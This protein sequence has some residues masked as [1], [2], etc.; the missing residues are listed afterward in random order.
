MYAKLRA[1]AVARHLE[2]TGPRPHNYDSS[3]GQKEVRQGGPLIRALARWDAAMLC[4]TVL[5]TSFIL[6]VSAYSP[7]DYLFW[8]IIELAFIAQALLHWPYLLFIVPFMTGILTGTSHTACEPT[9]V[10]T[11]SATPL[12]ALARLL[13]LSLRLG[14]VRAQT[15]GTA[16][17]ASSSR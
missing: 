7:R 17:C 14:S 13:V 16:R 3:A 6:Y 5:V 15:I 12:R 9:A 2:G 8:V 1:R 4:A 10:R 11:L